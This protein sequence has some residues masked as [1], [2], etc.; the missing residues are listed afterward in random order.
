[1]TNY[2]H[3]AQEIVRAHVRLTLNQVN[4]IDGYKPRCLG[5]HISCDPR[6]REYRALHACPECYMYAAPLTTQP[7]SLL[8]IK[9]DL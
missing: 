3:L 7:K 5:C 8:P 1:M 6:S 9:G 2:F 4:W